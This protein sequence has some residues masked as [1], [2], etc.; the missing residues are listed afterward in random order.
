MLIFTLPASSPA[1]Y[2][3][4]KGKKGEKIL[5]IMKKGK[6]FLT[7]M[8]ALA[9]IFTCLPADY[10]QA[11]VTEVSAPSRAYSFTSRSAGTYGTISGD[12]CKASVQGTSLKLSFSTLLDAGEFRIA[13]YGV[14][15][16]TGVWDLGINVP[17]VSASSYY[18]GTAPSRGFEYT[19]DFAQYVIPDGEYFLY[20]SR[21]ADSSQDF[22]TKVTRGALYK[23]MP[24]YIENGQ[25]YLV[26][27]D[28][29]I[30]ENASVQRT[31]K[32]YYEYLDTTLTDMRFLFVDPVTDVRDEMT[33]EKVSY[34][35]TISNRITSGVYSDYDKLLK[36]Y[37]YAAGNF[38]YDTVAFNTKKNQYADPYR[39]IYNFEN[40][41]DSENSKNG[42]VATTCQG[43][44]GIVV[45]LARAQGIPA[46]LIEGHR[47]TSP[48][49]NWS[50]E[51]NI[52]KRDHW[53]VEAYVNG[54][55][56][57]IDP[58]VGTNNRWDSET[59]KWQTYGVTNYTYFDPS[60]EQLAVSHLAFSIYKNKYLGSEITDTFEMGKLTS[61]FNQYGKSY[62]TN[63]R[64]LNPSYVPHST[65]TWGDGVINN[66]Y[67][68]GTGKISRIKWNGFGLAGD[69][70]F[71]GFTKLK[72][73]YLTDNSLTDA[74]LAGN[75]VLQK[76]DLRNNQI[77][78][79]DLT[80][81]TAL[82][83]VK[84]KGNAL[85]SA[86][87]SHKKKNRTIT[88]GDHGSFYFTYS[89]TAKYRLYLYFTPDLGYKVAGLYTDED[90]KLTSKSTYFTNLKYENY[91]IR[92]EPDPDSFKYQL[93]LYQNYGDFAAYNTAA[94]DRLRDL[95]YN[96]TTP[97]GYYDYSMMLAVQSFQTAYNLPATGE[98]DQL[99][100]S[101]LFSPD[102][103]PYQPE[104]EVSETP[105]EPEDPEEVELA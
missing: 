55:W 46:R 79:V 51:K 31:G 34:F 90:K 54:R 77:A 62:V 63:G 67:G 5:R 26:R 33:P 81:C 29:I 69:A 64:L 42:R 86:V 99:T 8:L 87:I 25:P 50:T 57:T 83:S 85:K 96:T 32:A 24:I 7:V 56:I 80:D 104:P 105:A 19:L 70:D 3:K 27:Y 97:D 30:A 1:G 43:F 37:D 35:R 12:Y 84:T 23:N 58:T 15:P 4:I 6:R 9:M 49:Y 45:A 72:Y 78:S 17:A 16:E 65:R 39:N 47:A 68:D 14:N 52:T 21:R 95:G 28:D 20:I 41:I 60:P 89:T 40:K 76:V 91:N 92:F 75:K 94:R 61:F 88:S 11:A 10:A 71:S 36:I 18:Y 38:Y 103:Q 53:W 2:F 48:T 73:L 44:S 101:I 59:G 93:K 98:I 13:L 66:F 102:P 74:R 100:W 22:E 82:T